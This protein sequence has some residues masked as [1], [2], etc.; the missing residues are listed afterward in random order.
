MGNIISS[1]IYREKNREKLYT[2]YTQNAES[3]ENTAL[4]GCVWFGV[5]YTQTI[6]KPWFLKIFK[7]S[8]NVLQ[9]ILQYGNIIN[10]Q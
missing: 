2:L 7:N 4:E 10:E 5:N 3:L 6:H 9:N 8:K 1:I